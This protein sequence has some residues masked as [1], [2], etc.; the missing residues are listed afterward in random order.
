M[1]IAQFSRLG[2]ADG[3]RVGKGPYETGQ[4]KFQRLFDFFLGSSILKSDPE[5][6]ARS[7]LRVDES[8]DEEW[9]F[10]FRLQYH[11][12]LPRIVWA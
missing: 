3:C 5:E 6:Q 10:L 2:Y 11:S 7:C 1:L 12:H 9:A 4:P 8:P